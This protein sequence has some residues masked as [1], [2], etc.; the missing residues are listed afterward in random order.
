MSQGGNDGDKAS[1]F[2]AAPARRSTS[3]LDG[4]V[5]PVPATSNH[6]S[7]ESFSKLLQAALVLPCAIGLAVSLHVESSSFGPWPHDYSVNFSELV[8]IIA[9]AIFEAAVVPFA[10]FK[11]LRQPE[12]LNWR[13][14]VVTLIGVVGF[15]PGT[16]LILVAWLMAGGNWT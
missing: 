11:L 4:F 14:V 2:G 12:S 7:S 13:N 16:V 5:T 3:S 8:A 9:I 10:V 6:R 15:L 1:S